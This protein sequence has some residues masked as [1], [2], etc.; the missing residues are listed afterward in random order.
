MTVPDGVIVLPHQ[1]EASSSRKDDGK[2]E[3]QRDRSIGFQD[4]LS[5]VNKIKASVG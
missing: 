5:Y 2:Q 4:A 3:L 1:Q